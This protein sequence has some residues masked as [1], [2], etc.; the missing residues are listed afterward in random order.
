[1]TIIKNKYMQSLLY[2]YYRPLFRLDLFTIL[3]ILHNDN[4]APLGSADTPHLPAQYLCLKLP[5]SSKYCLNVEY[6]VLFW[7]IMGLVR[8]LLIFIVVAFL[9]ALT[10]QYFFSAQFLSHSRS[11]CIKRSR[12]SSMFSTFT[13]RNCHVSE[14]W[15]WFCDPNSEGRVRRW[16]RWW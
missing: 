5:P 7:G 13:G 16:W 10:Q 6:V 14:N 12:P 11:A 1:M 2:T 4:I 8:S 15:L 3:R 9:S